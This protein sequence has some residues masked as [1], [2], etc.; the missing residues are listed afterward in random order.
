MRLFG[1]KV[2]ICF[3]IKDDLFDY[4]K[5]D[6]GKPLAIDIKEKKM[7][8][9][10]I[11]VL[12]KASWS[13]RRKIINI[14]RNHNTNSKKVQWVIDYVFENGGIDYSTKVMN[15]YV[16]QAEKILAN[17]KDSPAKQSMLELLYF[18]INRKK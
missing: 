1:E 14:V 10:L 9:P 18:T 5:D 12:N 13:E 11:H 16:V 17:F 7:T 2:G 3:Q 15:D 4:G 6:V 8:L